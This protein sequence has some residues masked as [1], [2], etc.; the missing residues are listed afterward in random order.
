MQS[1]KIPCYTMITCCN[2][3][4]LITRQIV[5]FHKASILLCSGKRDWELTLLA[6]WLDHPEAGI[7]GQST[8]CT[9]TAIWGEKHEHVKHESTAKVFSNVYLVCFLLNYLW[10][11]PLMTDVGLHSGSW[12]VRTTERRN[13]LGFWTSGKAE[14]S[15]WLRVYSW[16]QATRRICRRQGQRKR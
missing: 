2:A 15:D 5:C 1:L 7:W 6:Y 11:T 9:G 10:L 12:A 13:K 14:V 4:Q 8:P 3:V 16:S